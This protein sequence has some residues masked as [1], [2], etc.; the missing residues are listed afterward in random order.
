RR[1]PF[2]LHRPPEVNNHETSIRDHPG[3]QPSA[4]KIHTTL[5]LTLPGDPQRRGE[6]DRT[7]SQRTDRDKLPSAPRTRLIGRLR[8]FLNSNR[9]KFAGSTPATACDQFDRAR[10]WRQLLPKPRLRALHSEDRK[11]RLQ[12]SL[13]TRLANCETC[14]SMLRPC[15]REWPHRT[16]CR[17][18]A[19]DRY[20]RNSSAF[21]AMRASQE[22]ATS[23]SPPRRRAHL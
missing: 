1:N 2:S 12:I 6:E 16:K 3:L 5:R 9:S 21:P 15:I 17:R 20:R 19:I 7:V 14:P 8:E 11:C 10:V 4:G 18:R 22:H 13:R 23:G